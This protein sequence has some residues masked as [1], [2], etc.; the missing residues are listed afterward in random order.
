MTLSCDVTA[1]MDFR[2]TGGVTSRNDFTRLTSSTRCLPL[3]F[4]NA[5]FWQLWWYWSNNKKGGKEERGERRKGEKEERERGGEEKEEREIMLCDP[6]I[7]IC[8]MNQA[9]RYCASK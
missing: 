7:C 5:S 8:I 9:S 6:W 1:W 4:F 2:V 3:N